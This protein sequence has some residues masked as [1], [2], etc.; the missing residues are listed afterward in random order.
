MLAS[1]GVFVTDA[2]NSNS[3]VCNVNKIPHV[4]DFTYLRYFYCCQ[5]HFELIGC[6]F[7]CILVA[8]ASSALVERVF[9]LSV[10]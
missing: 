1:A 2:H 3:H 4:N 10:G 8:P 7:E 9:F 5:K 6:L